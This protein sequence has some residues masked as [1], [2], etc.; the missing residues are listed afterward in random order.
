MKREEKSNLKGLS[1]ARI[2]HS[3]ISSSTCFFCNVDF[4]FASLNSCLLNYALVRLRFVAPCEQFSAIIVVICHM[5][6]TKG[7]I[8]RN[9]AKHEISNFT[10]KINSRFLTVS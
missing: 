5:N 8:A 9:F 3:F 6:Q 10:F 4:I 1:K 2:Q 7:L